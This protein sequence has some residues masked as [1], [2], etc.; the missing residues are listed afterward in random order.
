VQTL[1]QWK[2][3]KVYIFWVCNLRY[4]ACNEHTPYCQLWP[5][6]LYNI[7]SHYHKL[8]NFRGVG[9]GGFLDIKCILIFSTTFVWDIYLYRKNRARYDHKFMLVSVWSTRYS[10][11]ILM[12]LGSSREIFETYSYTKFHENPS[13]GIR[14]A[15]RGRADMKKLTVAFPNFANAS[16]NASYVSCCYLLFSTTLHLIHF[17]RSE[18]EFEK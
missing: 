14:V 16:K 2:S 10:C 13:C 9:G 12:K 11:Q 15:A 7:F 5:L 4:P 6:R 1:F 17:V 8:L 3:Y 18:E